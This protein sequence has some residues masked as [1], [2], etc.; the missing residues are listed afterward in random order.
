MDVGTGIAAVAAIAALG[1]LYYSGRSTRAALQAA[2][3]AEEQTTIQ[4]QLARD[5][6]QP[7][8]WADIRPDPIT[9]VLLTLV[10][11]NSGPT[12]AT[13]VRVS[14]D[15]A[16]PRTEPMA[17][18]LRGAEEAL[19]RGLASLPPGRIY[20]WTL[21]Q[22]FALLN[23]DVPQA[24]TFT[25]EA[26][27]PFGPLPVSTYTVEL[28]SLHEVTDRPTGSLHE[29]TRAVKDLTRTIANQD[30]QSEASSS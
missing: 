13:N 30:D 20:T 26:D 9:G 12:V 8:V 7:F 6:A 27:G 19:G 4:R 1:A 15:A 29:L 5:S 10:V 24:Y 2:R 23:K 22:A 3:A 14:T 21:G 16:L 11:G 28:A 18:R 17:E 25:I